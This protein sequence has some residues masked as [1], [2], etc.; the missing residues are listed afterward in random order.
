MTT[1]NPESKLVDLLIT[2]NPEPELTPCPFCGEKPYWMSNGKDVT[3]VRCFPCDVGWLS[4]DHWNTRASR[5]PVSEEGGV[6]SCSRHK[7]MGIKEFLEQLYSHYDLGNR[8]EFQA[9]TVYMEWFISRVGPVSEEKARE[10]E[11]LRMQL[12]DAHPQRYPVPVV[13]G[14][15]VNGDS[16]LLERRAPSGDLTKANKWDIPG[17]KVECGESPS[18]AVVRELFEELGITVTV[19][20]LL[21]TLYA[22]VWKHQEGERH[23]LLAGYIC[24][25][26]S[27]VP[28]LSEHL[29]WWH[30]DELTSDLVMSPDLEMI[31]AAL[32]S[33]ST[34]NGVSEEKARAMEDALRKLHG[35][36]HRD[37]GHQ[38]YCNYVNEVCGEAL[39]ASSSV[40]QAPGW[41]EGKAK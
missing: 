25:L 21:P 17:G 37:M 22:S 14:I 3:V 11:S 19:K 7:P 10:V 6:H 20:R 33:S 32:A 9:A 38:E 12:R 31:R 5:S 8:D 16:V 41:V 29:K 36:D 27:G 40:T 34:P 1:P 23:W 13:C 24:N 39:T 35:F 2:P 30:I 18:E 26:E 4:L 15:I 28:P